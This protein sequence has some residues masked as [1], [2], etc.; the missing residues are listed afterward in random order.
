MKTLSL[1]I[2]AFSLI[3]QLSFAQTK[4]YKI[5]PKRARVEFKIS[6]LGVL[7]VNGVFTEFDGEV[8]LKGGKVSMLKGRVYVKSINTNEDA[9]DKILLSEPYLDEN[10][11][12]IIHY[13]SSTIDKASKMIRGE[14]TIK[15]EKRS[16]EM[17][18]E[19]LDNQIDIT[20]RISRKDFNLDF[21][22][23]NGLIG[24]SIEIKIQLAI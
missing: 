20:T 2:I 21:G 17:S 4:T 5:D 6:H 11:Y 10:T 14:L 12:P 13:Q 22:A 3:G 9:R 8:V 23:M 19:I 24:D 16:I 15:N 1:V 18:C 7:T